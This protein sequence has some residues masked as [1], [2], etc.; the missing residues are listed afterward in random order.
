[1]GV[2]G[3]AVIVSRWFGGTLLGARREKR[4]CL[5]LPQESLSSVFNRLYFSFLAYSVRFS[6]L[7]S[8]G[9]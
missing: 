4:N 3:V 9:L 8:N 2:S 1:M 7:V 5:I 6:Y